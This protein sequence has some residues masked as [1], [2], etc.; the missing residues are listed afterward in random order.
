[1]KRVLVM[2]VALLLMLALVGCGQRG[3]STES[4]E[5]NPVLGVDL[6]DEEAS[7]LKNNILH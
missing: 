5:I 7:A 2:G 1:M 6:S 4:S 3:D